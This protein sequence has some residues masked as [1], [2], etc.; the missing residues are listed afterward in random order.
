VPDETFDYHDV[1]RRALAFVLED[2]AW[3]PFIEW[4]KTHHQTERMHEWAF[5]ADLD[6]TRMLW[7]T[8]SPDAYWRSLAGVDVD[9][10]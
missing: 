6:E 7:L 1:A 10:V 5:S 3:A 8:H 9:G 4:C 2:E